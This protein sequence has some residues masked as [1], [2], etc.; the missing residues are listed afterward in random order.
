MSGD[1]WALGVLLLLGLLGLTIFVAI[2][3]VDISRLRRRHQLEREELER[4][5]RERIARAGWR[6]PRGR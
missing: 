1:A 5:I 4:Q 2:L 6:Q 3:V